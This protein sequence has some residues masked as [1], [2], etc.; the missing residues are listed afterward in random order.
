MIEFKKGNTEIQA[1]IDSGSEVNAII[2]AYI[3]VL[4]LRIYSINVKA[5]KIDESIFSTYKMMLASFQIEDKYGKVRF[6]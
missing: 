5:Q 4:G 3:A 2:P 6:F 1:L